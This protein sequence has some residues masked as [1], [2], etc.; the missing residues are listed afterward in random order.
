M[1][2]EFTF[3]LPGSGTDGSSEEMRRQFNALGQTHRTVNPSQSP[4]NPREGMPRINAENSNN[5]KLEFFINGDW[6]VLA[7]NIQNGIPQV[8]YQVFD[9]TTPSDTWTCDHNLGRKPLVQVIISEFVIYP[10]VQHT[11]SDNRVIVTHA[12]TETGSVIIIG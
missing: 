8:Q 12:S 7:Q 10:D 9:F 6:R 2:D 4:K 3:D 5:V 1:A 11:N